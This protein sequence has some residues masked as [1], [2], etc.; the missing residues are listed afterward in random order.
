[1]SFPEKLE[2]IP[3]CNGHCPE[4]A[5]QAGLDSGSEVYIIRAHHDSGMIIPGKLHLTHT[6]AFIPY[7]SE[8]VRFRNFDHSL[9]CYY[10][11]IVGVLV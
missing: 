2:W 7:S 4:N 10:E 5:I 1:M 8:E 3:A 9:K 11:F 6:S